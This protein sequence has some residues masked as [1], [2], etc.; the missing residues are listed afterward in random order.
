LLV[1]TLLLVAFYKFSFNPSALLKAFWTFMTAGDKHVVLSAF[2][3]VLVRGFV[4]K[5]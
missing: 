1:S 2:G 3:E 5:T 4:F